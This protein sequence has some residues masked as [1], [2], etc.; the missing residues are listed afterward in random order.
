MRDRGRWPASCWPGPSCSPWRGKPAGGSPGACGCACSPSRGAWS[1]AAAACG[2]A[3]PHA[4]AGPAR[5]PPRSSACRPSLPADQPA[6]SQRYGRSN[7]PGPVEPPLTRR[8][9]RAAS[10][11]PRPK[12]TTRRKDG[13]PRQ[14]RERSRLVARGGRL[15]RLR[16][17]RRCATPWPIK[18]SRI[19]PLS[20]SQPSRPADRDRRES[21]WHDWSADACRQR[22]YHSAI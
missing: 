8:D 15:H 21:G 13:P 2:S 6:P 1:A 16:L 19:V 5:S 18:S 14:P 11:G 10:N 22:R 17:C 4:G 3:S 9:S 20:S 7:S 12:I